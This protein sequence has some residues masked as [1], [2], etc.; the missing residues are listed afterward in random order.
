MFQTTGRPIMNKTAKNLGQDVY[1]LKTGA[2]F[3]KE[4]RRSVKAALKEWMSEED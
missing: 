2:D 1:L 3:T 4:M